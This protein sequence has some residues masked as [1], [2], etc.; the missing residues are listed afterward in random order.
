VPV[1]L[2]R[3]EGQMHGFF[4]MV[5]V[6]PGSAAGLDMVVEAGGARAQPQCSKGLS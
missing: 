6:L 5:D 4:I 3:V 1:E 2:R